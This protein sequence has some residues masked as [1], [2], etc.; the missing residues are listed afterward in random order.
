M[1]VAL[2]FV[3]AALA[4]GALFFAVF[5]PIATL[6]AARRLV[7][8]GSDRSVSG[9]PLVGSSLGVA[10]LLFAPIGSLGERAHWAWAP[11]AIEVVTFVGC[12]AYWR[13]SGL[14]KRAAALRR[15]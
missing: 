6:L 2:A 15:R 3:S 13:I 8:S 5:V 4:L 9:I 1:T 7:L 11:L 12:F 10:A 14:A